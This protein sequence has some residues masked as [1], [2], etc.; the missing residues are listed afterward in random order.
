MWLGTA[1]DAAGA[2]S[3]ERI[4]SD[5]A[6]WCLGAGEPLPQRYRRQLVAGLARGARCDRAQ[7]LEPG[8]CLGAEVFYVRDQP[9]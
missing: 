8:K 2:R 7:G 9:V 1:L 5:S 3:R 4:P 6:L